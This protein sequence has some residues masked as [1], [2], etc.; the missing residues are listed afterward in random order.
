[1]TAGL[2]LAG[3][4]VGAI[5]AVCGLLALIPLLGLSYS[6]LAV[7]VADVRRAAAAGAAFGAFWG[8]LLAWTLLPHVALWRVTLWASAGTVLGALYGLAAAYTRLVPG[9]PV[10]FGGALIGMAAA[11]LTLR[12]RVA[13]APSGGAPG[14][15]T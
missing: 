14:A 9:L 2:A 8:P 13:R 3:A 5:C 4:I 15:A 6:S 12:R 11:G 10:V 1:M 7:F